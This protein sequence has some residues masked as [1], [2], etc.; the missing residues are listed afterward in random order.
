MKLKELDLPNGW[1]EHPQFVKSMVGVAAAYKTEDSKH[2]IEVAER[3]ED[4]KYPFKVEIRRAVAG[5]PETYSIDS[6]YVEGYE[7]AE[8][9]VKEFASR[10]ITE[11]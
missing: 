4:D 7:E 6:S 2:F 10:A 3:G 8:E 9:K 1:K 5:E 11:I